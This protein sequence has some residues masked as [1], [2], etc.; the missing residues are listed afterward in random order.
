MAQRNGIPHHHDTFDRKLSY[1][2][3]TIESTCEICGE[4]LRGTVSD[5]LPKREVEHFL[6]CVKKPAPSSQPSS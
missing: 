1:D 6:S 3:M 2:Y 4:V 5:G